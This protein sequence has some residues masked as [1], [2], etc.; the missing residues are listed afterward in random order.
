[1][2]QTPHNIFIVC[3]VVASVSPVLT[4]HPVCGFGP[5]VVSLDPVGLPKA[6]NPGREHTEL[7]AGRV[8][9]YRRSIL[10]LHSWVIFGLLPCN[11]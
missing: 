11:S 9:L 4:S 7:S 1:M 2:T 5:G 10:E 8:Y 3:F 6:M